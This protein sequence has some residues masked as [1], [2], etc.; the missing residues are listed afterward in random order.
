MVGPVVE[1]LDGVVRVRQ[2]DTGGKRALQRGQA[3][4]GQR[5]VGQRAQA[6]E[7][8]QRTACVS[9]WQHHQKFFASG[10][11][12]HVKRPQVPA[13]LLPEVH[14]HLVAHDVAVAV[15]DLLEM[16][17]V[18]GHCGQRVAHLAR[19]HQQFGEPVEHVT[20]VVQTRQR[21]RQRRQHGLIAGL[22]QGRLVDFQGRHVGGQHQ[23]PAVSAERFGDG[24]PAPVDEIGLEAARG[25]LAV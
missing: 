15:V 24:A 9:V 14:Q 19:T 13:Q 7:H 23:R 4:D 18:D 20:A 10:A 25:G 6:A 3:F 21:I 22:A 2:R 16:I 1:S 8:V 17:E 11:S 5:A 12:D